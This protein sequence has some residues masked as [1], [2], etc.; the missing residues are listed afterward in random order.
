MLEHK[1]KTYEKIFRVHPSERTK[2]GLIDLTEMDEKEILKE[3]EDINGDGETQV[4]KI[5]NLEKTYEIITDCVAG[6]Y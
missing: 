3:M 2:E 5:L 1:K 6:I 4:T